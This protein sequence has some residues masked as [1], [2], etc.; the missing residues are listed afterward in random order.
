MKS[1]ISLAFKKLAQAAL[2]VFALNVI[3]K[4]TANAQF[5]GLMSYVQE[6]K[7]ALEAYQIAASNAENGGRLAYMTK[8]EKLTILTNQL[9]L[10]ARH[11]D[12]L[13]KGD[14][15][16]V[17]AAGFEVKKLTPTYVTSLIA[18]TNVQASDVQ[19]RPGVA[20]ISWDKSENATMYFLEMRIKGTEIWQTAASGGAASAEVTGIVPKSY[21]EFRVMAMRATLRSDYSNIVEV[22]VS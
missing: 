13:A 5:S 11:V 22:H 6:L 1:I 7:A 19:D 16:V 17:I 18:P 8:D 21:V 3:L 20:I 15:A 12:M 9:D 10:V 4:M 14:P 2:T